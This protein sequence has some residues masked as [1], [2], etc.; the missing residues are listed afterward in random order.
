MSA[1]CHNTTLNPRT[2]A[3]LD[4]DYEFELIPDCPAATAAGYTAANRAAA[5]VWYAPLIDGDVFYYVAWTGGILDP[6]G[7]KSGIFICRQRLDGKLIFAVN[8]RDYGLDTAPNYLGDSSIIP[9]VRPFVLGNTIY[10]CNDVPTN[11]G[12][13]LYAVDK[14]TGKLRYACAYY[15]PPGAPSFITQKGDYSQYVGSNMRLADL[16]PTGAYVKVG[17]KCVKYIFVGSSSLQ[18]AI[19]VGIIYDEFPLYTDQG[20]LFCIQDDGTGFSPVWQTPTCAPVLN[21]G[22]TL[23]QGGD[24]AFDPFPPGQDYVVILSKSTPTNVLSQPY[25]LPNPPA[26]AQPNTCPILGVVIFTKTTPINAQLVQPVW[27]LSGLVIYEDIDRV[28][29]HSLQDLLNQWTLEQENMGPDDITRHDIWTYL[30]PD[31]MTSAQ[32]VSGNVGLIYF[33][34]M[35]PGQTITEPFDAMSLNYWGNGTWGGP[36]SLDL[37]NNLIYWG[38]GQAHSIPLG[39]SL[40]LS[41][42][43]Y[44]FLTLKVPVIDTEVRYVAGTATIDDVNRTKDVFLRQVQN[45]ALDLQ[46][47]SPRGQMSYSDGMFASYIFS[48]ATQKA[49]ALAFATRFVAWDTYSFL[50]DSNDLVLYP[51][52]NAIDGDVSSGVNVVQE[53]HRKFLTTSAK[54][55]LSLTLDITHLNDAVVFDHTNLAAVGVKPRL[56]VFNGPNGLLGGSNYLDA[57]SKGTLVSAQGNMSWFGGSKG[58]DGTLEFE[59][60]SDGRVFD[61]NNSFIQ[62]IDV[63]TNKIIWSTPFDNRAHAQVVAYD[64]IIFAPDGSGSYYAFSRQDGHI[65]WKFDATTHGINGGIVAPQITEDGQVIWMNNYVAF[66]IVGR[67]GPNGLVLRVNPEILICPCDTARS[68]LRGKTFVSWDT[69]PKLPGPVPAVA[70]TNNVK[71]IHDWVS[72]KTVVA[73]HQI[74]QPPSTST[75]TFTIDTFDACAKLVTFKPL[76]GSPVIYQSLSLI[77][78][79]TYELTYLYNGLESKAW[80]KLVLN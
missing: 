3:G 27:S 40:L 16:C 53:C 52:N 50:N 9:R 63:K 42:P 6:V 26:P 69:A 67:P 44:N 32:G 31:Q 54:G 58:S 18:N 45:V 7:H 33:K 28:N 57:V 59:V 79:N 75:Y 35:Y 74:L 29:G 2:V 47:K 36:A 70:P 43:Q 80:L 78:T 37:K 12:P 51:L 64:D 1:C 49:G 39:E 5:Q 13:Q 71:I 23:V 25:F 41:Q 68:V 11:I 65:L 4:V 21:V 61:V 17:D 77:N 10:L 34:Q 24:P 56:L 66:G 62:G 46:L 8:C 55:G 60:T 20:F 15:P 48:T 19:N 22:D 72:S 30:T 73:T 38:C 76:L 14:R